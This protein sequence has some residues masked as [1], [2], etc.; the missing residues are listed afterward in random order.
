M[1]CIKR[2]GDFLTQCCFTILLNTE[3]FDTKCAKF[4]KDDNIFNIL[5]TDNVNYRVASLQKIFSYSL[6]YDIIYFRGRQQ[7]EIISNLNFM[8]ILKESK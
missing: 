5:R 1:H 6:N 4:N 8:M 2:L 3:Q 7:L